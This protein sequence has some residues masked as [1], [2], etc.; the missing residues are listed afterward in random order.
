M[1]N[2]FIVL[3][4]AKDCEEDNFKETQ[5]ADTKAKRE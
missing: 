1:K 2:P 4:D 5:N 3:I